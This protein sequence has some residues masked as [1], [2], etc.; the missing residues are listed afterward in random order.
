MGWIPGARISCICLTLFVPM[1]VKINT[2]CMRCVC[3]LL[4]FHVFR[5]VFPTLLW[6][7]MLYQIILRMLG[8]TGWSLKLYYINM[9]LLIHFIH[10]HNSL[11]IIQIIHNNWY[12]KIQTC[13]QFLICIILFNFS[14]II[15]ISFTANMYN[16]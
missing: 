15:R 5:E 9:V 1:W 7:L 14:S 12:F 4:I 16:L 3:L 6:S 11:S 2:L 8:M 13:I 10:L